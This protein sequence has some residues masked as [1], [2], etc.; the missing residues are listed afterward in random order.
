MELASSE[1]RDIAV[2][3]LSRINS[4]EE[5]CT[6]RYNQLNTTSNKAF[7]LIKEVSDSVNDINAQI[8][9]IFLLGAGSFILFLLGI[10]ADIVLRT[11][12]Q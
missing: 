2:Q 9:K 1:T 3:A 10:G 12:G 11:H 6:F 8:L 4:H 7:D 5:Q